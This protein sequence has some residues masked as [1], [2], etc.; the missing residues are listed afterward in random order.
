MKE[1]KKLL[2]V[3][4]SL[5]GFATLGAL[6]FRAMSQPFYWIPFIANVVVYVMLVWW[7]FKDEQKPKTQVGEGGGAALPAQGENETVDNVTDESVRK[8]KKEER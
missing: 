1:Y 5:V 6:G 4:T 8:T 7:L 2:G 3:L